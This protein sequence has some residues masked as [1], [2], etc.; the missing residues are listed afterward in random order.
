MKYK[1]PFCGKVF[2]GYGN[3]CAP[4]I[5]DTEARCCDECNMGVVIPAR[6]VQIKE[7]KRNN[8]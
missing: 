6:I 3:N 8:D 5:N 4:V 2:S 1:C 7:S